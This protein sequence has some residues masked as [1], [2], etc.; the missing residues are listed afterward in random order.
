MHAN[1]QT[2]SEM[3]ASLNRSV[4]YLAGLQ[5]RFALPVL[6]GPRIPLPTSPFCAG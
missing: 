6:S 4:V 2:L 5:K 3:A 1:P